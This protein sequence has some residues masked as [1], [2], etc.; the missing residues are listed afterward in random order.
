MQA[1]E[2]AIYTP[3]VLIPQPH[4]TNIYKESRER[5]KREKTKRER[6]AKH[7]SHTI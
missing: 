3:T 5:E 2:R 4:N 1:W 6:A 7:Q